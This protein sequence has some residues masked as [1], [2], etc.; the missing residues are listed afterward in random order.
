MNI[1]KK[2]LK[3]KPDIVMHSNIKGGEVYIGNIWL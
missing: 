3:M 2:T 1:R